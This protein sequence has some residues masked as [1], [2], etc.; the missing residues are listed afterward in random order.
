MGDHP[1]CPHGQSHTAHF[2]DEIPGGVIL[3]NYGKEPMRFDSH[4]ERKRWMGTHGLQEKEKWAPFPGTDKD[5]AGIP[6]PLG[7][8]DPQTLA[9]AKALICRN[10]GGKTED[11]PVKSGLITGQFNLTGTGRDALAVA[12][13]EPHRSARVG[14]RTHGG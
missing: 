3:E 9:N 13:G 2:R 8:V 4:S 14:R 1:F 11:D 10:G 5:P 6:N 7:Y 12:T